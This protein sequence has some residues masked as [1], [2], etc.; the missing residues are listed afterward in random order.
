STKT[1]QRRRK[2]WGLLSVKQQAHSI[3]SI[4]SLVD[5]IRVHSANRLGAKSIRDHL[6]EE[7]IL[8]SRPL[9]QNYLQ[10][11]DAAGNKQRRARKF[12]RA[13]HWSTGPHERWSADQHD[14]WQRFGLFLLV[15]LDNFSNAVLW[16][17]VWW[18]NSNP[19]LIASFY[20]EAASSLGGIPL[21]TQSD[22]G[23]ENHGMANAQTLLRQLLDPTL[24]GTLQHQWM[25]GHANI[26][27]EIF[28]SKLRRQWSE[29][30]EAVFED[31][32]T[33]GW[34]DPEVV[35]E[36]LLFRWLAVP[37]IQADLDRFA[38]IHNTSRPRSDRRKAM[39]AEIPMVLLECP[40]DYGPF[41]DYKI[42]VASEHLKIAA[43]AYAPPEHDVFLLVP[44]QFE[45]EA[46]DHYF[47]IGCPEVNRSSF[48]G[49]YTAIL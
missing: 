49:I 42:T 25:R 17:K 34:Y 48:W 32:L 46:T 5:Q 44:P 19:R 40:N 27:P 31:G 38:R 43:E 28:W 12:K 15:G 36:R 7:N 18:T 41:R 4:A 35:L 1:I 29:G 14:K 3:E 24:A 9:I 21:L 8:V 11:V 47:A 20:L 16:L 26:K 37:M 39:P 45:H 6:R 2:E 33:E 30:W 23:T 22:P 10:I 13:V